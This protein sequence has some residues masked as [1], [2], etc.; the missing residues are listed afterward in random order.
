MIC[1]FFHRRTSPSLE[2]VFPLAIGGTIPTGRLCAKCNSTL[3]GRTN[4]IPVDVESRRLA[5]AMSTH[6]CLPPVPDPLEETAAA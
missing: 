2:H 1:I 5:V 6:R 4:D 3:G